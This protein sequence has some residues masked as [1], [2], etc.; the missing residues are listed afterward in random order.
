MKLYDFNNQ[1][2]P[3]RGAGFV[4]VPRPRAEAPHDSFLVDAIGFPLPRAYDDDGAEDHRP[5]KSVR[6]R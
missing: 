5:L 2:L 3:K 6:R 1:P 4:S